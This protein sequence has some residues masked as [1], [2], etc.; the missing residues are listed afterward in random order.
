MNFLTKIRGD[1]AALPPHASG[2]SVALAFV[3]GFLAIAVIALLAQSLHVALV[4]GSFGASCVLVFGYPEVPF[5]QPRNVIAGH[6]FSTLIGLVFV[7]LC[8]PHWWSVALAV[9]SAIAMM[10]LTRTVH[11]PAGSNPVIVFLMQPGW[12][13]ALFPTLAGA[14]LLV[15]VALVFHN[16]TRETRWPKYW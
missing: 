1:S 6:L 13:F 16:V 5:S 3:G 2:K 4:L 9:G 10:M 11:P 7:H 15:L 14:V 12:G 8:G